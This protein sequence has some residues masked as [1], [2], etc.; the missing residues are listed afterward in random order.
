[1]TRGKRGRGEWLLLGRVKR[2]SEEFKPD[3]LNRK[4]DWPV[5]A[6]KAKLVNQSNGPEGGKRGSKLYEEIVF[7]S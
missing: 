1:M 7:C 5:A 4:L 6:W 3:V 2:R